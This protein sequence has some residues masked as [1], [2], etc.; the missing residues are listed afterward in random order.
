M[1]NQDYKPQNHCTY[2][3]IGVK[4]T[5]DLSML[6]PT[7]LPCYSSPPQ[8]TSELHNLFPP[9][10]NRR[11]SSSCLA[12]YAQSVCVLAQS[13]RSL[14]AKLLASRNT[15]L[16]MVDGFRGKMAEVCVER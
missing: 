3:L 6:Y 1:C 2:Q 13:C 16:K 15:L 14:K 5:F 4:L 11:E 10:R 12:Q 7:F 8:A 9:T